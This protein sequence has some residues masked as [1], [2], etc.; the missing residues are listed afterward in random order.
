MEN[1]GGLT[2]V[3]VLKGNANNI[4]PTVA[5]LIVGQCWLNPIKTT[6]EVILEKI[7]GVETNTSI[8]PY[9][10]EKLERTHARANTIP[11]EISRQNILALRQELESEGLSDEERKRI[12]VKYNKASGAYLLKKRFPWESSTTS[13]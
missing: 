5:L 4:L 6:N 11:D 8:L 2:F 3:E 1:G 7:S 13:P 9:M 12:Q 10:W